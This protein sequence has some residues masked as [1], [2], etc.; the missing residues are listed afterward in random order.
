MCITTLISRYRR[1]YRRVQEGSEVGKRLYGRVMLCTGGQCDCAQE[2]SGLCTGGQR[3]YGRRVAWLW[4]ED[5]VIV[6]RRVAWLWQEGS[7]TM[8]GEQRGYGR[9]P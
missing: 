5:S 6:H 1:T 4:Q 3:G 8:A 7:V 9:M 2:G